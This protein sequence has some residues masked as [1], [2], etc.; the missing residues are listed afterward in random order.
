MPK[1][2]I[3]EYFHSSLSL[4][5]QAAYAIHVHAKSQDAVVQAVR[6]TKCIKRVKPLASQ[7]IPHYTSN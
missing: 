5:E 1:N 7:R 2:P 3:Y 6:Q 4:S